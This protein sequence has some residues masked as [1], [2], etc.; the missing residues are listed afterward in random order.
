MPCD[1]WEVPEQVASLQDGVLDEVS[2]LAL[3]KQY[4]GIGWVVEDSGNKPEVYAIELASGRR[5]GKARLKGVKNR[6]F[7]ELAIGPCT[8]GSAESC[9]WVGE[10]GDNARIHQSVSLLR[11]A[12]PSP[13]GKSVVEAE[14]FEFVY[15]DGPQN[16][17]AFYFD[18][19]GFPLIVSKREDGTG[20]MY[21]AT[22]LRNRELVFTEIVLPVALSDNFFPAKVTAAVR[23]DADLLVR[24]YEA[25]WVFLE[26]DPEKRVRQPAPVEEQGEAI[27]SDGLFVWWVSEGIG[28][29][30]WRAR[31]G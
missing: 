25:T 20:W 13:Y 17:E 19:E 28:A 26:G 7:E 14:R 24:T 30:I 18:P 27:A 4:P 31:C 8:P 3:S 2:G 11:F 21:R 23:V 12:E 5:V 6:D 16:A 22:G 15:P 1:H 10:I 9:L 29:P